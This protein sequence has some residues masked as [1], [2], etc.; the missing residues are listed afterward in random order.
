MFY[1]VLPKG[2]LY[3]TRRNETD[4]TVLVRNINLLFSVL[5]T[6]LSFV[7]LIHTLTGYYT[8]KKTKYIFIWFF[9]ALNIYELSI[10]F[11]EITY[12]QTG[13]GY[14]ILSRL[15]F[16]VQGNLA[17][18]MT[19]MITAL[20]L[21]L[22]GEED[23][24]KNTIFRISLGL[25]GIYVFLMAYTQ[26]SGLVYSID[27][28][29]RYFRGPLFPVLITITILIMILNL[30]ALFIKRNAL[31][32]KQKTALLVYIAFPAVSMFLQM[33][34]FGVHLIS[35]SIVVAALVSLG[36][37]IGDQTEAY[38]KREQENTQL[39]NDLL[40]A[41]IQ[42]HFVYN[43]LTAIRHLYRSDPESA[44]RSMTGFADYLRYNIDS[45]SVDE[46]IPFM[47]EFEHVKEYLRLQKLRFGEDLE[48]RYRLDHTDFLIPSLTLQP[49]VD[50]AVLYGVRKNYSG[51]GSIFIQS[52]KADGHIEIS[53]TDDGPGFDM[54]EKSK[55][56]KRSHIGI[57]SA[58]ERLERLS[59]GKLV[60]DSEK[61][62]GTKVTIIL[63]ESAEADVKKEGNGG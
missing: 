40:L 18:V 17:S 48:V 58:A 37:I 19:V 29:N 30:S 57:S 44:E 39:K 53:V 51:K 11:R 12:K 36:I 9:A 24:L 13:Y 42:P 50:N 34:F 47:N 26:F 52:K 27:E 4:M 55:D 2:N 3:E 5:G 60:I 6:V 49:L 41:Q 10:F 33:I 31:S 32:L 35:L 45:L 16:F 61:G 7:G 22:S 46:P 23:I 59:S 63:P 20:L 28:N 8:S 21:E 38:R 15:L 62:K 1:A 25:W 54:D 14:I 43:C 56:R